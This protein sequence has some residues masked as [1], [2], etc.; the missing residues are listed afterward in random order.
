M[1]KSLGVQKLPKFHKDR[2]VYT[3]K[4][5][6]EKHQ[7]NKTE[8][9]EQEL[10]NPSKTIDFEQPAK[11][12]KSVELIIRETIKYPHIIEHQNGAKYLIYYGLMR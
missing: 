8:T 9:P 11:Y 4:A 12:P 5:C 1:S 7:L 10:D 3:S 6:S 2:E